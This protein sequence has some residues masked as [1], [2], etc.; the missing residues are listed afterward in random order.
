M[1]GWEWR[2]RRWEEI[3]IEDGKSMKRVKIWDEESRWAEKRRYENWVDKLR[4]DENRVDEMRKD[5]NKLDEMRMDVNRV[6]DIRRVENR[7]E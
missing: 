1:R 2:G 5:K 6:D 3:R 4:R 7:V